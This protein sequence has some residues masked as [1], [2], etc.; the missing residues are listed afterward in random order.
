MPAHHCANVREGAD[1]GRPSG[2]LDEPDSRL[3][4]WSHR[5]FG[6]TV[7]VKSRCADPRQRALGRLSPVGVH[8]TDVG[9]NDEPVGVE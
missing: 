6:E 2:C 3:D 8:G 4:L 7:G 9:E 5:P 1:H